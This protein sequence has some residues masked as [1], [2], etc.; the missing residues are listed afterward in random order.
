[1]VAL[2]F[3]VA[4]GIPGAVA[5]DPGEPFIALLYLV[6]TAL[7][8]WGAGSQR[9][10]PSD[11]RTQIRPGSLQFSRDRDHRHDLL[12]QARGPGL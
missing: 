7:L 2:P 6:A 12:P 3:Q 8:F 11:R 10:H 5:F 9:R 4:A 1:M